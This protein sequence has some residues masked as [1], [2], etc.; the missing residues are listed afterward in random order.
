MLPA[1]TEDFLEVVL[2]GGEILS[3]DENVVH[4]YKTEGKLTQ[5]E[6]VHIL[7]SIPSIPEAKGHPQKLEHPKG[8][9]YSCLLDVL[10]GHWNLLEV[11][12]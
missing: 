11:Q 5:D 8:G 6:I 9:D 7:E 3:K 1:E 10:G 2:V 12:F 4:I